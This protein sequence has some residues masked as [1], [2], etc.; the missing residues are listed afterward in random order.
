MKRY[1]VV[2]AAC[3]SIEERVDLDA[4]PMSDCSALGVEFLLPFRFGFRVEFFL[5][6]VM[7]F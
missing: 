2:C 7:R 4:H 5:P 1:E 3:E 6:L